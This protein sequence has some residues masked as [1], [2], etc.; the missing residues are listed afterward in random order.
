MNR[1]N[2]VHSMD[3]KRKTIVADVQALP[4]DDVVVLYYELAE[5][6]RNVKKEF[7]EC[8]QELHHQTQQNKVLT[9]SQND[10]QLEIDSINSNHKQEMGEAIQKHLSEKGELKLRIQTLLAEKSQNEESLQDV[11]N[12]I[13]ELKKLCNE[14][15]EKVALKSVDQSHGNLRELETENESLRMNLMEIQSKVEELTANNYEKLLLTES[16]NEKVVCLEQNLE[17]RKLELEEKDEAVEA[18]QQR[19]LEIS[20]SLQSHASLKSSPQDTSEHKISM[21]LNL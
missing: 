4:Q 14:L 16:L 8:K 13:S 3:S 12:E 18:L 5:C 17:C 10:L 9:S 6:Y 20:A 2:Q 1:R 19:L 15:K 11:N 7:E 21:H